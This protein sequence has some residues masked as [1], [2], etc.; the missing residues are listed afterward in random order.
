[1]AGRENSSKEVVL[2]DNT[3]EANGKYLFLDIST[4]YCIRSFGKERENFCK[5]G[6]ASNTSQEANGKYLFQVFL[7]YHCIQS[8]G[9][10]GE[11][12]VRED[13]QAIGGW[14]RTALLELR[15]KRDLM[16]E[17]CSDM[18]ETN[19][20]KSWKNRKGPLTA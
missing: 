13:L 10:E 17:I 5:K 1:M 8:F 14:S 15:Y 2:S 11:T 18:K 6:P 9:K 4:F 3:Q 7:L 19:L 20:K 16:R 12:S